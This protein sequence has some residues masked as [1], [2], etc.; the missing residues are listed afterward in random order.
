MGMTFL[1]DEWFAEVSKI[2]TEHGEVPVPPTLADL[3]INITVEGGPIG[4]RD[5]HLHGGNF[6]EGHLTDAPTKLTVPYDVAKKIFIDRD[7]QAGMQAFMGGQIR[8]EGDMTKIMMLQTA[9]PT[10]EAQSLM[11]KIASVTE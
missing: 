6:E 7:Q 4:S 3:K 10:A 8:V 2:R 5:V 11:D 9:Q 1:T